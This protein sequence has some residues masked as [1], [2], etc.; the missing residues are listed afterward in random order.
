MCE[1]KSIF[2]TKSTLKDKVNRGGGE[3]DDFEI[4]TF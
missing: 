3:G 1:K 4:I 2:Q